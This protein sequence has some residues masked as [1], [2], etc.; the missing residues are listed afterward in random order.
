MTTDVQ[1]LSAKAA[2]VAPGTF[3]HTVI[4][5][6]KRFKSS[7]VELG[8]L[9][10]KVRDEA[11]YEAWGYPTFEAYCLA[12]LRIRK[13]TAL[14]LTRSF[15]FLDKHEPERV[16]RVVQ[17]EDSGAGEQAPPPWE[18]VQVL[19]DAEERGQLSAQEY[20]SIRDSIWN[21]DS[22]VS[23]LRKELTERFPVPE[24]KASPAQELKRLAGLARKLATELHGN[25][26]V[27]KAVAERADALA[28]DVAELASAKAEA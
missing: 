3:R 27:P 9:L 22:Q 15:S 2:A 17:D 12:E 28:D 19:A 13:N 5:A 6:A 23:E 16:A 25:R 4:A 1:E 7:W 8:K 20:K 18:V 11:Q 26:S 24:T 10:T 14:K 21:P